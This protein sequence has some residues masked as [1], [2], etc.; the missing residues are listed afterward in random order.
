VGQGCVKA[1]F[2]GVQVGGGADH[3]RLVRIIRLGIVDVG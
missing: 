1:F 3:A 2:L